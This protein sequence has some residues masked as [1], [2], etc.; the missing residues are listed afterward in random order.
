[1]TRRECSW[2]TNEFELKRKDKRFCNTKCRSSL[3]KY[4]TFCQEGRNLVNKKFGGDLNRAYERSKELHLIM[5]KAIH[6]VESA[7]GKWNV[8]IGKLKGKKLRSDSSIL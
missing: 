6:I 3:H 8:E 2:C 7:G 1:M 4:K 5:A